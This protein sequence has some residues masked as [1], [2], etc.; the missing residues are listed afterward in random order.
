M[1]RLSGRLLCAIRPG[2]DSEAYAMAELMWVFFWGGQSQ[3]RSPVKLYKEM[4]LSM[5]VEESKLFFSSE[6][7]A[8]ATLAMAFFLQL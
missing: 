2:L 8:L 4:K 1:G 3:S 5:K 7:A 6:I